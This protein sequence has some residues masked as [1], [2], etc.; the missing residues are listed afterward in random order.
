[1]NKNR[2]ERLVRKHHRD[3]FMWASQ[4]CNYNHEDA[5]EVLQITYLK[6]AEGKAVYREQAGF[7]TWLF[8]VIRFTAIDFL[9]KRVTFE[10]LDK[11]QVPEEPPE[12]V[13]DQL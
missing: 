11:L 6:I 10:G 1:M 9:K 2:L 8:S 13:F 3:A 4:C 12:P 7:K 5:K